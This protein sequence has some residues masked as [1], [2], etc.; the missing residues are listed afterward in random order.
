MF[1]WG[2]SLFWPTPSILLYIPF[3]GPCCALLRPRDLAGLIKASPGI[4]VLGL[5]GEKHTSKLG[6][7]G[8]IA[9]VHKG[10]AGP[11]NGHIW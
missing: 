4:D 3:K 6:G 10:T 11:L 5:N 7:L 2:F 1:V 8:T 9:K